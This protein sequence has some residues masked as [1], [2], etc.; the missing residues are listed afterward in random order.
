MQSMPAAPPLAKLVEDERDRLAK[1]WAKLI[2]AEATDRAD[3]ERRAVRDPLSQRLDELAR[4]LR[5]HGR[6]APRLFGEA[7]RPHGRV[8]FEQRFTA[9]D[10]VR[11]FHALGV[12]LLSRWERKYGAVPV[13]ATLLVNELVA[14]G[15]AGAVDDFVR[16]VRAGRAHLRE[17]GA[18]ELIVRHLAEG[19]IAVEPDGTVSFATPAA[20]RI[21]GIPE[22]EIVGRS[23]AEVVKFLARLDIRDEQGRPLPFE[24]LPYR[25]ALRTG[26]PTAPR[27]LRFRPPSDQREHV[28]ET[29]AIPFYEGAELRGVVE[30]VRDRTE[31]FR[32]REALS[33]AYDALRELHLRLLRRSRGE[34][35]G[36]LAAG[37]I[38]ALKN[39]MNTA[40]LR[41]RLAEDAGARRDWISPIEGAIDEMAGLVTRLQRLVTKPEGARVEAVKLDDV[42]REAL[43]LVRP[44]LSASARGRGLRVEA[45][46]ASGAD[47]EAARADLLE[48]IVLL[49]LAATDALPTGGK[50]VVESAIVDDRARLVVRGAAGVSTED[51]AS[52]VSQWGGRFSVDAER[53]EAVLDLA[54]A[55]PSAEAAPRA[56]ARAEGRPRRARTVLV[57]DDEPDNREA[58]AAVLEGAGLTVVQAA[59][60]AEA[61]HAASTR[62][63]D[64]ALVDVAMP[65]GSGRTLAE[66][67]GAG[68][69]RLRIALVTGYEPDGPPGQAGA[70]V[71][72]K[73]V[74]VPRLLEFLGVRR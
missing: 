50:L 16:R 58:L 55:P 21:L 35:L 48:V 71:F 47:V 61:R 43:D 34:A 7:A 14:A 2:A 4:L 28:V 37:S 51:L 33:R 13:E 26:T 45:Q 63:L 15:A 60:F 3:T 30:T 36:E 49:L 57:V 31:E 27:W 29:D 74:N 18:V 64:A 52:M 73:P 6:D 42:A 5:R 32:Q 8:R 23:D 25:V 10:L 65:E 1:T 62:P 39:Q 41:C 59:S 17:S 19:L 22:A 24:E 40:R 72:T 70:P 11:E 53:G 38:G 12:V 44:E 56:G 68:H 54:V 9:G 46:L 67:L 20:A 66:E 69:P